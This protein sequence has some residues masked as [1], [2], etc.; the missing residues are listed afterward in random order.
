[1]FYLH[2]RVYSLQYKG[3]NTLMQFRFEDDD[4]RRLY[5]EPEFRLSGFG[6]GLTK[7]YRKL[8]GMVSAAVDE[9]DLRGV[10]S[11]HF[12]KLQGD[13]AGQHSLKIKDQWRLVVTI[14]TIEKDKQVVVVEVIDYH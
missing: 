2:N 13:R 1:M 4:L 14:E 5:E 9:R 10:K 6:P 3:E 12:E 7:A 8:M 11:L